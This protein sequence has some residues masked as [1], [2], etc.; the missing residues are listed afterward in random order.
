MACENRSKTNITRRK[1]RVLGEQAILAQSAL[2][3]TSMLPREL[4]PVDQRRPL[5][6][7]LA[8]GL[9]LDLTITAG[10]KETCL[11]F[12]LVMVVASF[13]ESRR[14]SLVDNR[15]SLDNE[16]VCKSV[17]NCLWVSSIPWIWTCQREES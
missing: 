11:G 17:I 16:N 10:S 12:Q 1:R 3:L 5:A 7:V 4:R 13:S 15:F 8:V 2:Y 14:Q 6:L 9:E